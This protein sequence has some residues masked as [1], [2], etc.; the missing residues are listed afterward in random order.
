MNNSQEAPASSLPTTGKFSDRIYTALNRRHAAYD[1]WQRSE[2]G[3]KETTAL[4]KADDAVREIMAVCDELLEACKRAA[5]MMD[6]ALDYDDDPENLFNF[7]KRAIA[8][9]EG[10]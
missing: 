1:A 4:D 2:G 8:K 5:E 9:A 6:L 10:R 7:T 3:T